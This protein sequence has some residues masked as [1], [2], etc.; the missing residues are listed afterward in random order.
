M[1]PTS[2]YAKSALE[3]FLRNINYTQSFS[4]S[5][6]KYHGSLSP[7]ALAKVLHHLKLPADQPFLFPNLK[8]LDVGSDSAMYMLMP[9][10]VVE[11]NITFTMDIATSPPAVAQIVADVEQ[12][13][14]SLEVFCVSGSNAVLQN[15]DIFVGF[16]MRMDRLTTISLPRYLLSPSIFHHLGQHHS[17]TGIRSNDINDRPENAVAGYRAFV[18]RWSPLQL[19]L[20][21][22]S[23][24]SLRDLDI[25]LMH[26]TD[27]IQFLD[28][29]GFPTVMLNRFHFY[30]ADPQDATAAESED[31]VK[32]VAKK[33]PNLTDFML[34]MFAETIAPQDF[35]GIERLKPGV[36][37]AALEMR[38]I[39]H[40]RFEHSL[41]MDVDDK[42]IAGFAPQCQK[43]K[44]L[45]LNSHPLG[46][47]PP[48]LT[49]LSVAHIARNC[50]KLEMLGL[51]IDGRRYPDIQDQ[52][53]SYPRFS[54]RDFI[55]DVGLSPMP[56]DPSPGALRCSS[57]YFVYLFP[58]LGA[59]RT[60]FR[61][62]VFDSR[63]F[64]PSDTAVMG[65]VPASLML[66]SSWNMTWKLVVRLAAEM[67]KELMLI[68]R[69]A[70]W[71]TS[72]AQSQVV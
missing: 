43:L 52:D 69:R 45:F 9:P 36:V 24:A 35:V 17:L 8:S 5:P 29:T 41:P 44:S 11:L 30:V 72:S 13:L 57:E 7:R 39:L 63:E 53:G 60:G 55:L 40:V 37:K 61:R 1:D 51:Y 14:P 58:D 6:H 32:M 20:P 48:P 22:P 25:A 42:D 19:F 56:S 68:S 47:F 28:E 4:T 31:F 50:P 70:Q 2:K 34:S 62:S 46:L 26:L 18:Q 64:I 21:S 67:R 59:I 16:F 66:L 3:K 12:R 71:G 10:S 38:N 33:C 54:Y 49:M 27:G 23:F 15:E 65:L